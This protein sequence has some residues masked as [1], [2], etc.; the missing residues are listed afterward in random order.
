[1]LSK[2]NFFIK[3]SVNYYPITLEAD[4]KTYNNGYNIEEV[5]VF[6]DI[7]IKKLEQLSAD[8][9]NYLLVLFLLNNYK[10]RYQFYF[11]KKIYILE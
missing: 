6:I 5:N 1:M 4:Y 7:V 10:F 8:N 3:N 11:Y 2:F 9:N